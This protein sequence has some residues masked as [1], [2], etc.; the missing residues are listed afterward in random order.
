[1]SAPFMDLIWRYMSGEKSCNSLKE[2]WEVHDSWIESR[3]PD[4]D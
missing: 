3:L 1:M 4:A 2:E